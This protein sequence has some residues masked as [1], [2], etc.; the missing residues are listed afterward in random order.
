MSQ[1]PQ[2]EPRAQVYQFPLPNELPQTIFR[3]RSLRANASRHVLSSTRE[4]AAIL[5]SFKVAKLL[6]DT[7][8]DRI[9][10]FMLLFFQTEFRAQFMQLYDEHGKVPETCDLGTLGTTLAVCAVSLQYLG[11]YRSNYL[12]S[13]GIDREALQASIL[14]GIGRRLLNIIALESMEAVHTCVLLGTFYLFHGQ[15]ELAWPVCGCGLR[16]A[17]ALNLHRKFEPGSTTSGQPLTQFVQ[18]VESRKRCWWAI[19]E[20][21]TFCCMLY[22]YPL[23]IVDEDCDVEQLNPHFKD[24]S[25]TNVEDLDRSPSDPNHPMVNLLHYKHFMSKLSVLIKTALNKL[26]RVGASK[27]K[28][29]DGKR[30]ARPFEA[31]QIDEVVKSLNADLDLWV[32]HCESIFNNN[33]LSDP[34]SLPYVDTDLDRDIG[35]KS[36]RFDRHIFQLQKLVLRFAFENVRILVNRPLLW[37]KKIKRF[38]VSRAN[39]TRESAGVTL[40]REAALQMSRLGDLATFTHASRTYAVAFMS[41]HILTAGVTLCMLNSLEPLGQHAQAS[42]IGVHQLMKM[43]LSLR[44]YSQQAE[45][46]LEVL[47]QLLTLVMNKESNI[48]LDLPLGPARKSLASESGETNSRSNLAAIETQSR[49][50]ATLLETSTHSKSDPSRASRSTDSIVPQ[51]IADTDGDGFCFDQH[52]CHSNPTDAIQ[53]PDRN[54]HNSTLQDQGMSLCAA[55]EELMCKLTYLASYRL[56]HGQ[57]VWLQRR[58][59]PR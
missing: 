50:V 27:P 6:V 15:P 11:E 32:L 9:H 48:L 25:E 4:L 34:T 16:V 28:S 41:S 56:L 37:Y 51:E 58:P 54:P 59:F 18:T 47:K 1:Q 40:C 10:W 13:L 33:D 2:V 36:F 52:G 55:K 53:Y 31:P 29:Q 12:A 57:L 35:A 23:S 42:K 19:Y 7:Y 5:P 3:G 17:Q 26:Y 24:A 20:V 46:G 30:V 43:L 38:G 49:L 8:F 45:Q 44:P 22:G 21:E 39:S 14:D